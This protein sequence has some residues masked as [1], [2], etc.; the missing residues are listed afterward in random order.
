MAALLVSLLAVPTGCATVQTPTAPSASSCL[1]PARGD[2]QIDW[3]PFVVVDGQ[4]YAT[5][6]D[7]EHA[8]EESE[9]GDVVATVS[10]R[11]AD[12]GDPD[13]RPRDGDSAY[14]PAGTSLHE[15]RGRAPGSALAALEDGT[16]R[17]FTPVDEQ[18]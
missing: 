2:A 3:V 15:V 7:P 8:L 14:L 10:C 13:F 12:V 9:V 16:W 17:L 6:Y 5:S 4:M 18:G 11:I 1:P